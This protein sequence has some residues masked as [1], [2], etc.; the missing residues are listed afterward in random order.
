MLSWNSFQGDGL[1]PLSYWTNEKITMELLRDKYKHR[2]PEKV[3]QNYA[4]RNSSLFCS[5]IRQSKEMWQEADKQSNW[6]KPLTLYYAMMNLWKAWILTIYPEYPEQTSQLKHGISTKKKKKQNFSLLA[7]EIRFQRD[8]L[9]TLILTAMNREELIGHVYTTEQL[10][11]MLPVL[12]SSY[13]LV[14]STPTLWKVTTVQ[15]QILLPTYFPD[16]LIPII[17]EQANINYDPQLNRSRE[18]SLPIKNLAS[19]L[20]IEKSDPYLFA[21]KDRSLPV[22]EALILYLL[23]FSFS[24]L[25]RYDPALWQQVVSHEWMKESIWVEEIFQLTQNRF[26]TLIQKYLELD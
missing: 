20:Y 22:P 7:D 15:D 18:F 9:T 13:L 12:Q 25:C 26:P 24:M 14:K 6:S 10:V 8:G 4:F 3:A 21:R 1:I 5:Y 2:Y 23:L 19:S 17:L 11:S 16:E